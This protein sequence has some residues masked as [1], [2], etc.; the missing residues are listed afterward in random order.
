MR[1]SMRRCGPAPHFAESGVVIAELF[2]STFADD[3]ALVEDI[4]IVESGE[5]V[6]AVYGCD[7]GLIGKGPEKTVEDQR[8]GARVHAA[9]GLIEQD[10]GAVAG[11][12]D[13]PGQGQPLFLTAGEVD[14]LFA[15]VS[16]KALR[17]LADHIGK[18]SGIANL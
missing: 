8:F 16:L 18:M 1:M 2:E 3:A 17:Q 6:E 10:D 7:D 4:D 5:E 11:G 14:A 9:G 12:E 13:T 15:D